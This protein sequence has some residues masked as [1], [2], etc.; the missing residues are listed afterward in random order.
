MVGVKTAAWRTSRR[1]LTL[2][3][4]VKN[5]RV[6]VQG[7][8]KKPPMDCMSHRGGGGSEAKKDQYRLKFPAP[9]IYFIVLLRSVF[10]M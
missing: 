6:T 10:L 4:A 2:H 1:R 8:V 5:E 3:R 9:L 7:P